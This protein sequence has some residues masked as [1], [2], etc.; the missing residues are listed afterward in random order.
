MIIDSGATSQSI[1]IQIVDDTGLPVTG[2][3]AATFPTLK[4]SIAGP[5]A[6]VTFPTLSDLASLTTAYA[7]GGVRERGEGVYRVDCPNAMFAAAGRVKVRGEA[8]GKRVIVDMIDVA[9]PVNAQRHGG[10]S[11]TARDIGASVLL[12]SGTG[13]GQVD[14]LN[15]VLKA[16][17]VQVLATA[18]TETTGGNLAAA[19]KKLFDVATPVL[20][21]AS[22]NQTGNNYTELTNLTYGLNALQVLI[23]SIDTGGGGGF[24]SDDRTKLTAVHAVRPAFAPAVDSNGRMDLINAPNAVAI[25]AFVNAIFAGGSLDGVSLQGALRL[26][27]AGMVGKLSGLPTNETQARALDDSKTRITSTQDTNGNVTGVVIDVT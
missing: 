11:Q 6:D 3:V 23:A 17:L 16:N 15:G 25:T 12:S 26:L 24:T 5:N 27:L 22:V 10:A 1:D 9:P 19:F 2:L 4:Y 20:T 8:T 21:A 14:L 13:T 7:S 18:L